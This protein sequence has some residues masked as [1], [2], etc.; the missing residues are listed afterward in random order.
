MKTNYLNIDSV[1]FYGNFFSDE[2]IKLMIDSAGS[3]N[4]R[5]EYK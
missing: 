3:S 4:Y 2:T 1:N 5:M